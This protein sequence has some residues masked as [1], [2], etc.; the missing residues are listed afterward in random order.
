MTAQSLETQAAAAMRHIA[1]NEALKAYI[2]QN[3]ALYNTL[4]QAALRFIGGETLAQC[5]ET[6]LTLNQQEFATTIDYMGES[7][8]SA[9]QVQQ[10]TEEFLGV[11]RAIDVQHLN[12]SVSLDLSHIGL[13]LDADLAFENASVIAT[14]ARTAGLEVMISREGSERTA[15]IIKIHQRLCDRF[16]NVGITLQARLHRT[17]EDLASILEQPGKIR[18][19]KG[20]YEEP[21]DIAWTSAAELSAA[22]LNLMETLLSSGHTCAIA[23][24]DPVLLNHAHQFIES[25]RLDCN[26]IEFE[27]LHGVTPERLKT[28]QDRGYHTRVYLPYGQEWYLYLCH[29]IAEYP[30][31]LYQALIDAVRASFEQRAESVLMPTLDQ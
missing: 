9:T 3:T 25:Q 31:N 10:V 1:R 11:V 15:D 20:A 8:R 14:A 21:A 30:P 5:V 2:L 6:V 26:L 23:T 24:H 13:A 27:M 18:L 12:S 16:D 4:L 29:R 28:M 7:T 19:V 17:A 22:Y